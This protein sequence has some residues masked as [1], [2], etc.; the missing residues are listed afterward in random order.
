MNLA[1]LCASIVIAVVTFAGIRRGHVRS[2]YT[3]VGKALPVFALAC[4]VFT[5]SSLHAQDNVRTVVH[6]VAP[7]YPEIAKQMGLTGSVIVSVTVDP[8]GKVIKAESASANKVFIAAAVTAIKQWKYAPS[9][10]T[11]TF[12]ITI[13]F[14]KAKD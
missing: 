12:P 8:S 10:I 2:F 5:A 14:D 7:I 1:M 4:L 3:S 13:N 9:E 6:K 11:D